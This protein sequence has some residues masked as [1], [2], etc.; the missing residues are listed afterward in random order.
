MV[1]TGPVDNV[2]RLIDKA[3]QIG[4]MILHVNVSFSDGMVE[5]FKNMIS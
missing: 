4:K 1:I 5:K 2:P 3:V